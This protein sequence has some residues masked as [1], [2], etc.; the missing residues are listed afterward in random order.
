[1]MQVHFVKV[2][3]SDWR[4]SDVFGRGKVR[5]SPCL[6]SVLVG[7]RLAARLSLAGRR[8]TDHVWMLQPRVPL[9]QSQ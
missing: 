8:R 7:A 1:M 5:L 3:E 2:A 6:G 9:L 4:Q